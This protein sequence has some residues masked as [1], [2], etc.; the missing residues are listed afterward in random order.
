MYVRMYACIGPIRM[1][2]FICTFVSMCV[3]TCRGVYPPPII[4][5]KLAQ[6]PPYPEHFLRLSLCRGRMVKL[7]TSV[8]A[9]AR[10]A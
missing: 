2:V 6:V 7:A 4:Y 8:R 3:C 1:Y 9:H 5:D 10:G